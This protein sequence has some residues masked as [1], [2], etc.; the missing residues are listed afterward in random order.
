MKKNQSFGLD[1]FSFLTLL[2]R[3]TDILIMVQSVKCKINLKYIIVIIFW[4]CVLL[5]KI[6]TAFASEYYEY[7]TG[8][9]MKAMGGSY[10][11]TVNDETALLQ[12][13][14]GLGK[15]RGKILTVADPELDLSSNDQQQF[16]GSGTYLDMINMKSIM[17]NIKSVPGTHYHLKAQLFPSLVLPDF[18]FGLH[19]KRS[20]DADT[21]SAATTFHLDYTQDVTAVLGFNLKFFGGIVKLGVSARYIDRAEITK[22]FTI[23]STTAIS[24]EN[25]GSE[26]TGLGVDTGLI[27]QAPVAWLP[28][29]GAVVHDVG[30]TSYTV[31]SGAFYQAGASR[32][33]D[34]IQTID[35]GFALFPI[36]GRYTRMAITGEL[37]NVTNYSSEADTQKYI[38][39]GVEFNFGD[40]V[41]VRAGMNQRYYTAGLEF[42]SD[43]IQFQATT[44]GEEIGTSTA[45]IEDRRYVGKFAFRF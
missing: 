39:A 32:P 16:S 7:Y 28:S 37:H 33:R 38:H 2:T 21:N 45:N 6:P 43:H 13:P 14:A 40:L 27:I 29:I 9:R 3:V 1:F 20:Y 19:V 11:N 25:S 4:T 12:N 36:V 18:G 42:S 15:I 44:Y 22:D 26:G 8:A 23:A 41:F 30:N 35:A 17:D 31:G 5:L 34:S 10:V 24:V